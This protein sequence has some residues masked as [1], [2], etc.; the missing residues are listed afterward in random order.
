M[1]AQVKSEMNK[2]NKN[3][4]QTAARPLGLLNSLVTCRVYLLKKTLRDKLLSTNK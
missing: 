4:Q 3:K 1:I 2:I